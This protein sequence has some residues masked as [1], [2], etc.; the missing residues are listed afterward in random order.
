[1]AAHLDPRLGRVMFSGIR[2]AFQT[3]GAVVA[4]GANLATVAE[5]LINHP[6]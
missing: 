6:G 2:P 4:V 5:F 3:I 1:M